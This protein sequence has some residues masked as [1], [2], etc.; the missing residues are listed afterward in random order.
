MDYSHRLGFVI[1]LGLGL[2]G[3]VG[4]AT[5]TPPLRPAVIQLLER[6]RVSS[7]YV[8]V[9][10]TTPGQLVAGYWDTE[11]RTG[12]AHVFDR[13]PASWEQS[14]VLAPWDGIEGDHRFG[15]TVAITDEWLFVGAPAR[16]SPSSGDA[17]P[18]YYVYE[19][20]GPGWIPHS[21][22]ES[23]DAGKMPL[24]GPIDVEGEVAVVG[25]P[26]AWDRALNGW[27]SGLVFIFEQAAGSWAHTQTLRHDRP[28]ELNLRFGGSV[29][30]RDGVI[31]ATDSEY[32]H[33]AYPLD[34]G[35]AFVFERSDGDGW[36]LDSIIEEQGGEY[37][38]ATGASIGNDFIAQS[39]RDGRWPFE[40]VPAKL[41]D[42]SGAGWLVVPAPTWH[43]ARPGGGQVAAGDVVVVAAFDGL[44]AVLDRFDGAWDIVAMDPEELLGDAGPSMP[45]PFLFGVAGTT[46]A[47]TSRDGGLWSVELTAAIAR[48][49]RGV[50]RGCNSISTAPV[51]GGARILN[52][53][54]DPVTYEWTGAFLE[55][56]G[57]VVTSEP[58]VTLSYPIRGEQP[59]TLTISDGV[60]EHVSQSTVNVRCSSRQWL[61]LLIQEVERLHA[62]GFLNKGQATSLIV[63]L[64]N[65]IESIERGNLHA[66]QNQVLAFGNELQALTPDPVPEARSRPMTEAANS[67]WDQL[68]EPCWALVYLPRKNSRLG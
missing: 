22:V 28:W 64:E 25:A 58:Q 45:A 30:I 54:S 32:P 16:R 6:G 38:K 46:L 62:D 49:M 42:R 55:G 34:R 35:A 10:I 50:Q 41:I 27:H 13:T 4:G 60:Y 18:A 66:A 59:L 26:S 36:V 23:S 29:A 57:R 67:I 44:F 39:V 56:G 15:T 47:V 1:A 17:A 11:Q 7:G 8:N 5:M 53:D 24:G 61:Q 21:I 40:G 63:K 3:S 14:A 9:D 20:I 12:A 31:V 2:V 19:R 68:N 33:A 43:L 52:L 65:A 51:E 48:T 37:S